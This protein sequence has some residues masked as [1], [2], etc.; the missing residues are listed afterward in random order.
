MSQIA[1]ETK[2]QPHSTQPTAPKRA[3][4][5]A[6]TRAPRAGDIRGRQR[7]R[8]RRGVGWGARGGCERGLLLWDE[9][10]FRSRAGFTPARVDKFFEPGV[11]C[12]TRSGSA[13]TVSGQLAG[14]VSSS[15]QL[16]KSAPSCAAESAPRRQPP[17]VSFGL[18]G[19]VSPP[20][21]GALVS[22]PHAEVPANRLGDS[23][24]ASP[25]PKPRAPTTEPQRRFPRRRGSR[26]AAD[27]SEGGEREARSSAPAEFTRPSR[28]EHS[29]F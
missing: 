24:G 23:S 6:P 9:T 27:V 20:S 15:S 21:S 14:R 22:E 1:R 5:L 17:Q 8:A 29:L 4:K 18:V 2:T 7:M 19:G 28:F 26:V 10:L 25:S 11:S 12:V 13:G 16:Q 3:R